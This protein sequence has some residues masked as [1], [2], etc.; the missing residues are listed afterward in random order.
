MRKINGIEITATAF[1][2]DGCHKIYILNDNK[3]MIEA[4][5]NDYYIYDIASLPSC[6]IYSCS[7]RFINEWEGECETI[8][9]QGADEVV[10][11]GFEV[12]EDLDSADYEIVVSNDKCTLKRFE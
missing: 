4:Q 11:E 6:F 7:L 1:A 10:F 8:V 12:G 9:P 2:Y 5:E 3:S